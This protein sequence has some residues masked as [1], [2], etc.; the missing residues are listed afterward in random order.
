M[1]L[2]SRQSNQS[3]A[4]IILEFGTNRGIRCFADGDNDHDLKGH[5]PLCEAKSQEISLKCLFSV[6]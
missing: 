1:S 4:D 2:L 5:S 3:V 6:S